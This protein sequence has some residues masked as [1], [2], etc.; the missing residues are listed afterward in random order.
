MFFLILSRTIYA[1]WVSEFYD[2]NFNLCLQT[3]KSFCATHTMDLDQAISFI[4]QRH[5]QSP[6]VAIGISLGGYVF[7]ITR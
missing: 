6:L 5:P 4:K 7:K 2:L 1:I 3:A